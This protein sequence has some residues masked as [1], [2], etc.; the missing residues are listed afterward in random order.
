MSTHCQYTTLNN[1]TITHTCSVQ[2]PTSILYL[3]TVAM[4]SVEGV[5]KSCGPLH[6]HSHSPLHA[7]HLTRFWGRPTALFPSKPALEHVKAVFL[8]AT[9]LCSDCIQLML[10]VWCPN[11]VQWWI[12]YQQHVQSPFQWDLSMPAFDSVGQGRLYTMTHRSTVHM[13]LSD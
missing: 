2:N 3:V 10:L 9:T 12:T 7:T 5:P 13:L 6:C 8:V 11:V 1:T 4:S